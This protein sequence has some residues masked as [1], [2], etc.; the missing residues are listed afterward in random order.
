[1]KVR[2]IIGPDVLARAAGAG[3]GEDAT[4]V[5][6]SRPAAGGGNGGG[7]VRV[8]DP[9]YAKVA[10]EGPPSGDRGDGVGETPMVPYEDAWAAARRR[11]AEA[12]V[13]DTVP[14]EYRRMVREFFAEGR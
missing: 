4:G 5:A 3:G 7:V 12:L 13:G 2:R 8:W 9:L 1:V 11:A 14:A 6:R 10:A